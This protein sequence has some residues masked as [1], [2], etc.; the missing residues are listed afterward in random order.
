MYAY[1]WF[2][3]SIDILL[4]ACRLCSVVGNSRTQSHALVSGAFVLQWSAQAL[5]SAARTNISCSHSLAVASMLP[6]HCMGW[7]ISSQSS[8]SEK[9]EA[10]LD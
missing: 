7:S 9:A 2:T 3:C 10:L 1:F 6:C 4:C 8:F 5:I